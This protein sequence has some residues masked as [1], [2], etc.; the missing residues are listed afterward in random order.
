[1][2]LSDLLLEVS[3]LPRQDKEVLRRFLASELAQATD[4][5]EIT[6]GSNFVVWSPYGAFE[7]AKTLEG[8]T[9]LPCS[10]G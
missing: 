6:D 8:A 4:N 2:S 5:P 1:M 3:N 7:A 9:E 10:N